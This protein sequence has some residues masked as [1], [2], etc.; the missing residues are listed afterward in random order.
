M[1]D[2]VSTK[3]S[4]GLKYVKFMKNRAYHS[5]IKQSSYKAL[6]GIEPRVGL[7]TSS[8]PQEIINDIQDEDNLRKVIE[9]DRNVNLTEDSDDNFAEVSNQEK[10]SSSENDIHKARTTAA[11]NLVK[12]AKKMKATSDKSQPPA[13]IGDNVTIPIPDVD[14]GKGDLRNNIG[15]ISI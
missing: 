3:W 7:S 8:L 14:K 11:E 10:V 5:G 6:F 13:N 9:D 4:E 1:K 15:V 12:Q 2:N